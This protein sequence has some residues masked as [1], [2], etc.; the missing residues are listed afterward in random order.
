MRQYLRNAPARR[1]TYCKS[2]VFKLW[3]VALVVLSMLVFTQ[4]AFAALTM[5]FDQSAYSGK[6]WIQV[7]DASRTFAATYGI[8]KHIEFTGSTDMMSTPVKLSDIG[9]GG[10]NITHA[11]GGSKIFVFYD[12]PT[13]NSRTAAPDQ[14]SPD[15]PQRYQDVELVMLGGAGDYG[16]LTYIN[17]YSAPLSIKS[18]DASQ[19]L[20][21]QVGFGSATGAEI[22]A[23][24]AQASG[25]NS[26]AVMKDANGNILRYLG[27]SNN[28]TSKGGNPWP[29]F[30]PYI[31][32]VNKANQSTTILNAANFNFSD[33][34]PVY[35]FGVNMT[36]T[37]KADGGIDIT[38]KIT[39]ALASG[40]IKAN[41]PALPPVG[42]G[43]G[44]PV[45]FLR[46]IQRSTNAS[47]VRFGTAIVPSA[48]PD[49]PGPIFKPLSK[50]PCSIQTNRTIIPL[51]PITI[52]R[53]MN[54][55]TLIIKPR[56][57]VLVKSPPVCSAAS[58]TAI[59]RSEACP[60][61][62]R[63]WPAIN[64]GRWHR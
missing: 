23:Q 56:I 32:S 17:W 10:L 54:S 60:L 42:N 51:A 29:S 55:W 28:F 38:G 12:D 47:M 59:T 39:A 7:Q 24:M 43:P 21:Q 25:G 27:P 34:Q 16:D 22:T 57:C 37:A 6:V 11:G 26:K 18:Y 9:A 44:P 64:G 3:L 62:S 30:V 33:G 20:L 36:A 61:P 58:S 13:G 52:R 19:K 49:R 45:L 53:L 46:R 31:Q 5:K 48:L 40:S 1:L 35:R 63:T 50:P 14:N 2:T 15:F 8:N 4:A 41:N